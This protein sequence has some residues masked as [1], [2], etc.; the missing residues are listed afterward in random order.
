MAVNLHPEPEPDDE[1]LLDF[2]AVYTLLNGGT[3]YA[4]A[5]EDLPTSAPAAAIF[6]F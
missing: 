5:P 2:A 4:L 6:R 1:D 3:V